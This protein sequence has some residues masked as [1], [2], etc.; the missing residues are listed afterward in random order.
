[1]PTLMTLRIGLPVWPFH[2]PLRT[3]LEK[4]RKPR[5]PQGNRVGNVGRSE[6]VENA[7]WARRSPN[8]AR[9]QTDA[10]REEWLGYFTGRMHCN[11]ARST[12]KRKLRLEFLEPRL[13]LNSTALAQP[14]LTMISP[15]LSAAAG[16]HWSV[17][18]LPPRPRP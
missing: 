5:H 7:A 14:P 9:W 4:F 17:G 8:G 13:V 1:M 6:G 16:W 15:G 11:V 3:R 12:L 2:S 10:G 18:G